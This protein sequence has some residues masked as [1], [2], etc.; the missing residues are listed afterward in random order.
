[1]TPTDDVDHLAE[2]LSAQVVDPWAR[3]G[4]LLAAVWLVFLLFPANEVAQQTT[5][6]P[7]VRLLGWGLILAFALVYVLA[8][9][10]SQM[11]VHGCWTT[12]RRV[13]AFGGFA[14]MVA[15]MAALW[16][17]IGLE[18]FGMS[19]FL[20]SLAAFGWPRG[21]S[22]GG[23]VGVG[24]GTALVIA[25]TDDLSNLWPLLFIPMLIGG[26]GL[27]L[28]RLMEGDERREELQRTLAVASERDRVARDVHDVLGHSL[29]V[30]SLKADLA[31]RLVDRDPERAK[32]EIAAIRSLTRQSLAEIRATVSGLRVTRLSDERDAAIAALGDA[33]IEVSMP[34]DIDIVDPAHRITIAWVLREAT[35]NVLRHSGAQHADVSWG[36]TW[37]EVTDDGRGLRGRREGHGLTG[38][39]ERLARVGGTLDVSEGNPGPRGPGTRLRVDLP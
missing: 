17:I 24:V 39:R 25:V 10:Q 26:F 15:A 37:L 8:F 14:G 30:V 21:W 33:G 20:A 31:E 9:I 35:T 1:M 5:D 32:A 12:R 38:L 29:T 3:H 19:A 27:L 16:P 11:G 34:D 22:V 23:V 36:P 28:R 4:W 2:E 6:R 18:I 7:V 13:W